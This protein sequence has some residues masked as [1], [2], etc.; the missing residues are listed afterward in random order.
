VAVEGAD[1][2]TQQ[3]NR[4]QPV[5]KNTSEMYSADGKLLTGGRGPNER[6]S[7]YD[8]SLTHTKTVFL[9]GKLTASDCPSFGFITSV[10]GITACNINV[11]RLRDMDSPALVQYNRA[12]PHF[13]THTPFVTR[14]Y[15]QIQQDKFL[16]RI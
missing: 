10:C 8:A 12:H 4:K 14:Q 3:I 5:S 9:P 15:R 16:S 1:E 13:T 2:C 6:R 7:G 11:C